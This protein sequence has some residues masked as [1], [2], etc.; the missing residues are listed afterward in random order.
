MDEK[1]ESFA[2]S[3]EEISRIEENRFSLVRKRRTL[4]G[5]GGV[6]IILPLHFRYHDLYLRCKGNVFKNKRV[7]MEYIHKKKAENARAKLL[8]YEKMTSLFN[9]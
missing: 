2:S 6:I 3:F 7:L 5:C 1:N 8:A 9:N 4:R